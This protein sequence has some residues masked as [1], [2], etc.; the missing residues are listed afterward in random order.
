M[1]TLFLAALAFAAL[2]APAS[3]DQLETAAAGAFGEDSLTSRMKSAGEGIS[4]RSFDMGRTLQDRGGCCR[5]RGGDHGRGGDRDYG[6]RR[7]NGA[8]RTEREDRQREERERRDKERRDREWD[9]FKRDWDSKHPGQPYPDNGN[10]GGTGGSSGTRPAPWT[11]DARWQ[12]REGRP[13]WWGWEPFIVVSGST[14]QH[15]VFFYQGL[16]NTCASSCAYENEGCVKSCAGDG[17]CA[18]RCA[19]TNTAC[20]SQCGANQ[21][22][23]VGRCPL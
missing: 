10:R 13:F 1:K 6:R 7:E 11:Y 23:W 14:H 5:D 2:A 22:A 20:V 4:A 21:Q 9:R 16:R 18:S 3:A 12:W 8:D 17:A 19:A 15:C